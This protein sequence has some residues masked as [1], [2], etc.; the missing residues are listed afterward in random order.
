MLRGCAHCT[1]RLPILDGLRRK[2]NSIARKPNCNTASGHLGRS[3]RKI[4]S[5]KWPK[6]FS[7]GPI[8]APPE[9]RSFSHLYARAEEVF[10]RATQARDTA[11]FTLDSRRALGHFDKLKNSAGCQK[12]CNLAYADTGLRLSTRFRPPACK[13]SAP[14]IGL[15]VGLP[16][17]TSH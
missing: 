12:G 16:A 3:V 4:P 15:H 2:R 8:L 5:A 1:D 7:N 9:G 11:T 10:R 6:T 14:G 17:V 13:V